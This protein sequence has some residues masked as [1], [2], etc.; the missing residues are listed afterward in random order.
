MPSLARLYSAA[1][2]PSERLRSDG[3]LAIMNAF[4]LPCPS[5][6]QHRGLV[7]REWLAVK[8]LLSVTCSQYNIIG[9]ELPLNFGAKFQRSFV[10]SHVKL[11]NCH[12]NL[13][14]VSVSR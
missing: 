14:Y 9:D 5:G 4:C 13:S 1:A 2:S 7:P 10:I 8:G 12:G 6:L 3:S 11:Q